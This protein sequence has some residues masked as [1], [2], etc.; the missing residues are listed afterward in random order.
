MVVDDRSSDPVK[1]RFTKKDLSG[2][3]DVR[4][5]RHEE[6]RGANAARN[7]GIRASDGEFIDFLGDEADGD[8]AK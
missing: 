1:T 2:L 5:L 7:T 4:F 6:N 3:H 8:E